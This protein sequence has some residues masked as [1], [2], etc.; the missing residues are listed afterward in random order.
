MI[1]FANFL[2]I[3]PLNQPIIAK[4][5]RLSLKVMLKSRLLLNCGSE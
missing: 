4:F 1:F 3:L 2:A 5:C